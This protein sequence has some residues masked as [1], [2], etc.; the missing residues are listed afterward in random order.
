[1]S[2]IFEKRRG[3]KAA[4][5]RE[6]AAKQA[7]DKERKRL[8]VESRQARARQQDEADV[9]EFRRIIQ[10]ACSPKDQGGSG[11]P[12]SRSLLQHHDEV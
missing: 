5:D 2:S 7:L 9:L 8:A 12:K 3:V 10:L 1:M 6:R 11:L 4:K